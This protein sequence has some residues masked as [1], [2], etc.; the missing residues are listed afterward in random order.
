LAE[1][2][3]RGERAH[4]I[5]AIAKQRFPTQPSESLLL[6]L[7]TLQILSGFFSTSA[8]N[9]SGSS[10]GSPNNS[11]LE[12]QQIALNQQQQ[13]Q[14]QLLLQQQQQQQQ[15]SSSSMSNS[16]MTAGV[17]GLL[18]HYRQHFAAYLREAQTLYMLLSPATSPNASPRSS[19]NVAEKL[20]NNNTTLTNVNSSNQINSTTIMQQLQNISIEKLLF[21]AA[22]SFGKEAA[23]KELMKD[24]VRASN[25]Y[26]NGIILLSQLASEANN[27]YDREVIETYM[28]SFENRLQFVDNK[29]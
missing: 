29:L 11:E 26:K 19:M 21:D 14:Q 24:F 27:E 13:Q 3:N 6:Y 4:L 10:L 17:A 7:K 20:Q 15:F 8:S 18:S 22:I 16:N 1:V 2:Q 28:G 12:N 5:A 23:S 9:S 25:L